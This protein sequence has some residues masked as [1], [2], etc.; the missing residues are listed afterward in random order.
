MIELARLIE[1]SLILLTYTPFAEEQVVGILN[2]SDGRKEYEL[3]MKC[4]ETRT[5]GTVNLLTNL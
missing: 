2:T 5:R 1:K 3:A 4:L